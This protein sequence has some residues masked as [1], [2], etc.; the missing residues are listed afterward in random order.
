MLTHY[1]G[2][3]PALNWFNPVS[4]STGINSFYGTPWEIFRLSHVFPYTGRPITI[5]T[6]GGGLPA[7]FSILGMSPEYG[8]GF[9]ILV[10]G[11]SRLLS[12]ASRAVLNG[13]IPVVEAL[14][15][16]QMSRSHTGVFS[17]AP[18]L[19]INSSITIAHSLAEG[20]H[21]SSWVSNGTDMMRASKKL[22]GS[23]DD[24]RLQLVPTLL[25]KDELN[26]EG[27]IWRI[28]RVPAV[29]QSSDNEF[30][31]TDIDPAS[32]GGLPLNEVVFWDRKGGKYQVF[33]PTA[34]RIKLGRGTQHSE[35]FDREEQNFI[36]DQSYI[37]R[38]DDAKLDI[39]LNHGLDMRFIA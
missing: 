29:N 16:Q 13:M 37:P 23:S 2:L 39:I 7:Y 9:S 30:C 31:L 10:G 35:G 1:N 26:R 8:Y 11:D 21:I 14:A 12:I 15:Q 28:L 3:T 33:E 18:K 24:T 32:Y 17:A 4:Y 38:I 36:H 25:F 5:V 22:F 6:K 27:E 20:L 19:D 34:F